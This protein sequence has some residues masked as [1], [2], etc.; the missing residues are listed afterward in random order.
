[1]GARIR[2][3]VSLDSLVMY[4]LALAFEF[5]SIFVRVMCV[6]LVAIVFYA[7]KGSLSHATT[8]WL[9]LALAPTVWSI[10]AMV[11][12]RGSGWWWKQRLGGREPASHELEGYE[13]ALELLQARA[14]DSL[15]APRSWFVLDTAEMDAAVCGDA[16]MLSR[17][18]L[19]SG[20]VAPVLAHELGHL[21]TTDGRL[22]AAINRL[23][24]WLPP[25][26]DESEMHVYAEAPVSFIGL[27]FRWFTRALVVLVRGG[28]GLRFTRPVLGNYWRECE[29]RADRYAAA[30]GQADD[31][32]D[33]LEVHALVHDQ[34]VP[35]IWLTEHTHPPTALR[36][37]RLRALAVAPGSEPV[38]PAPSGRLR[39][40]LTAASLTEPDPSAEEAIRSAGQAL[41]TQ[42]GEKG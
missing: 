26:R 35:F 5:P 27:L 10:L 3:V 31:L 17:R 33:F 1:M 21:A 30:L 28:F 41:P 14:S 19:E 29:Y 6:E 20:Y 2:R 38:K 4:V 24:L 23:V 36:I 13:S 37:D 22:T 8:L 15:P 16:L 9:W 40:G 18:L 32:A 42:D 34:P 39:R 11:T 7:V 25:E 12:P